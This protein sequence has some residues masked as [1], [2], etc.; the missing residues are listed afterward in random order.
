MRPVEGSSPTTFD[1]NGA[2]AT[3]I[4][5]ELIENFVAR[6]EYRRRSGVLLPKHPSTRDHVAL[7]G[8]IE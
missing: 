2:T 1:S 3:P 4:P 6:R 7:K 5:F 8:V